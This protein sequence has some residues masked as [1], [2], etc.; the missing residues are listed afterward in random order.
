LPVSRSEAARRI[1]SLSE[2]LRRDGLR[3]THQRLEVMREIAGTD[4]HPDVETI[5]RGVRQRVPTISL[6]TV[7]RSL[8]ALADLGFVRRVAAAGGPA[9]YDANM[10]RHQHFVCTRCGLVRDIASPRL[11]A[12]HSMEEASVPG[13]VESVEVQFKGICAQCRPPDAAPTRGKEP[14]RAHGQR[15]GAPYRKERHHG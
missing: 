13:T 9:R 2:A 3:L 10:S 4:E 15:D 7:Y 8:G 6:D 14:R 12:W 5:Y 11:D 1:E